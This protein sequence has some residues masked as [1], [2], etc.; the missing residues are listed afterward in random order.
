[1]DRERAVGGMTGRALCAYLREM[2]ELAAHYWDNARPLRM[3]MIHR[4]GKH[5]KKV[6]AAGRA[7]S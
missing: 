7:D 4:T 1:V 5:F 3:R 6:G 2:D